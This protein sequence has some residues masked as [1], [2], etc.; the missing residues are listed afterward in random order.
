VLKTIISLILGFII[1]FILRVFILS[2][3]SSQ[4]SML[5][6]EKIHNY[7]RFHILVFV[8]AFAVIYSVWSL[9]Q[10]KKK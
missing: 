1:E 2:G 3:L 10:K 8:I 6:I 7:F 4:E 9:L 5:T